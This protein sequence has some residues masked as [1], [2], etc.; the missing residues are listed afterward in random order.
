MH[1]YTSFTSNNLHI[2]LRALIASFMIFHVTSIKM[3]AMIPTVP[4]SITTRTLPNKLYTTTKI[5]NL[6]IPDQRRTFHSCVR[7]Y[8]RQRPPKLDFDGSDESIKNVGSTKSSNK[9]MKKE[10]FPS[11]VC[12]VCQRPFTWRKKWERSWD[13][14]TTCS[15]KCN[16]ERR[17]GTILK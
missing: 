8:G 1:R 2:F 15:K 9:T 6:F 5:W 14:I 16:S 4:S 13:E 12:V 10:N 17:S 7:L 3:A 11:K